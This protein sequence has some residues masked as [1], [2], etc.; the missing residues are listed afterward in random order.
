MLHHYLTGGEA[1]QANLIQLI[2]V[3]EAVLKYQTQFHEGTSSIE[4]FLSMTGME[5]LM[6]E[7]HRQ[8]QD[9]DRKAFIDNMKGIEGE[10]DIVAQKKKEYLTIGIKLRNYR[11]LPTSV[12]TLVGKVNYERMA[13]IPSDD[14]SKANLAKLGGC[15]HVYPLD[16][17]LGL[18]QLPFKLTLPV[19]LE[20]AN[21]C[22]KSESYQD[23][24]ENLYEKFK[25]NVNDDTMR[26]VTNTVGT[27]V[28]N[29]DMAFAEGI[30]HNYNSGALTLPNSTD[31]H[32]LYLEID[33]AMLPTRNSKDKGTVYKENKLGM[34]F[35][36]DNFH[37][38]ID[39]HGEPQHTILKREY[40]AYVGDSEIFTKLMLA[41][42]IRN[43]YGKYKH[44]VLISDGATWIRNLK[45]LIFPDAQQILDFYH[46]KEHITD[47]AKEIFNLDEKKYLPWSKQ[48][49]D[50][51]KKGSSEMA[52]SIIDKT[53]YGRNRNSCEKLRQYL[54]NNKD[55]IDYGTYRAKG[56]F[57]GSG[58]IESSN[59]TVL[60]RRLKFASTRW[61]LDSGQAVVSLMSKKRSGLWN[62]D[63]IKTLYSHFKEDYTS[64][65]PY[66]KRQNRR[67]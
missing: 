43:G 38:W 15:K 55:N 3:L 25:I 12:T 37:N 45:S 19:M 23:A 61:N 24:E 64:D 6:M 59:K 29:N 58:A 27:I 26:Q 36:S 63:V 42:A 30:W 47:Y 40:T 52:F 56:Y 62:D 67:H 10:A 65:L 53:K 17:A 57:I 4:N 8:I 35:S 11:V 16:E 18:S 28:F 50:L 39:K 5:A 51:F 21:E 31:D 32:I 66:Y 48:V 54:E 9:A 2:D 13:L 60:Q 44:T 1:T 14:L 20:I 49:S 7:L 33:G 22:T 46:L 41:L 34:A